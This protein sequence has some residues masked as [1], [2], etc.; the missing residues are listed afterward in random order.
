M[1]HVWNTYLHLGH[2]GGNCWSLFQTWSIWDIHTYI[3]IYI[4]IYVIDI[5]F[6]YYI[7]VYVYAFSCEIINQLSNRWTQKKLLPEARST[8]TSSTAA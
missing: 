6:I 4:Y 2:F 7:E 1:L 8:L 5:V 3:H